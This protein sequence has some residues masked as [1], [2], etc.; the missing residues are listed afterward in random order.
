MN[1]N[2]V[3]YGHG[4][5]VT[6]SVDLSG[7]YSQ[8]WQGTSDGAGD[9]TINASYMDNNGTYSSGSANETITNL[10]FECCNEW[11]GWGTFLAGDAYLYMYDNNSA[12]YMEMNPTGSSDWG[13]IEPQTATS[14]VF[15]DS[16]LAG[17]YMMGEMPSMQKSLGSNVGEIV[18]DSNGDV[19]AGISSGGPGIDTFDQTQTGAT[20]SWLS[21]DY[22]TFSITGSGT[23]EASCIVISKTRLV[24]INNTDSNSNVQIMQQ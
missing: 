20:A 22:G 11:P 4:F 10:N 14:A 12:F 16:A 9:L 19:T 7:Y 6:D 1:G 2:F 24:C 3:L 18:A 8:I 21:T 23:A 5:D 17:T 15:T 13:S